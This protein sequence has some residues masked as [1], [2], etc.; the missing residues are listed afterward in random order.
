MKPSKY[1][2]PYLCVIEGS[3]GIVLIGGVLAFLVGV[4]TAWFAD[5]SLLSH[6]W[7]DV[8]NICLTATLFFC[9]LAAGTSALCGQSLVRRGILQLASITPKGEAAPSV[10]F[11]LAVVAWYCCALGIMIVIMA[12]R[13][14]PAAA[15]SPADASLV[16]VALSLLAACV[17]VGAAV[18]VRNPAVLT[19]P[20]LS[21]S[22]F[23]FMYAV[24]YAHG[25]ASA[26]SPIY[27][28][29]YYQPFLEPRI[30]LVVS[31]IGLCISAVMLAVRW[32]V[33]GRTRLRL[34]A[35]GCVCTLLSVISIWSFGPQ[36]V[37]SRR[38]PD[39]ASCLTQ[40]A[41][42][43]CAWPADASGLGSALHALVQVRDAGEPIL[44]SPWR[45]GEP[46]LAQVDVG[47][48]QLVVPPAP[49]NSQ[50]YYINAIQA[51]LPSVHCGPDSRS[52][53]SAH[54]DLVEWLA[55]RLSSDSSSS[56]VSRAIKK[57]AM[58]SIASQRV[59]VEGRIRRMQTCGNSSS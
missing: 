54:S 8:F 24:S 31:Q 34:S 57:I 28:S 44:R 16:V 53:L 41:T 43:L 36:A 13:V 9:P 30:P 22:V 10:V 40:E 47:A 5:I 26:L 37:Q 29:V 1:G 32:L 51:V 14:R 45:Y 2:L 50:F 56:Y 18:G 38:P 58:S 25:W 39:M 46:G 59:W 49:S 55:F 4:L 3:Q 23:V 17:S 20:V 6:S 52:A 11:A 12:I 21:L 35:A 27:P 48:R 42:R 7:S 19:P 33:R 15:I